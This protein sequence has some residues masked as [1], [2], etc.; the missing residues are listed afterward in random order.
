MPRLVRRQPLVDRIQ[1]LLN[2]ADLLLWLSEEF[3]SHGW[4]HLEKEWAI[5]FGVAFNFV[6][7]IARANSQDRS[8]GGYD[9]VFGDG[10]RQRGWFGWLV[11]LASSWLRCRY[12]RMNPVR[13]YLQLVPAKG[14]LSLHRLPLSSIS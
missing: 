1:S 8:L 6:F 7:V 2:P 11:S 13:V 12:L 14:E 10:R 5:P 3:E 9:D 4:D